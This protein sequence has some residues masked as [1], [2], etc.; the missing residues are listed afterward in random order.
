M[1]TFVALCLVAR[2]SYS[3]NDVFIGRLARRYGQ[4]E[5]AAFRGLSLGVSMAPSPRHASP[6][7]CCSRW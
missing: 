4:V 7:S 3:L 1:L 2:F 6:G 5:V